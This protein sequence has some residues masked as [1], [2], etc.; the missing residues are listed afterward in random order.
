[1]LPINYSGV[2]VKTFKSFL[3]EATEDD[4]KLKHITHVEDHIL[5]D[6]SSGFSHATGVLNKVR[7]HIKS[8][9]KDATLTM[10][11]DGCVSGDSLLMTS[12]GFQTISELHKSWYANKELSVL[13]H[14][15]TGPGLVLVKDSFATAPTKQWL[16]IEFEDGFIELTEDHEVKL[17]SGEWIPANKLKT[18]DDIVEIYLI[19]KD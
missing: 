3:K 11:H 12:E 18:N 17:F 4:S 1:M 9:K 6:G 5:H 10:K 13:G 7:D 14:T 8:G 2:L 19:P 16:K 15:P